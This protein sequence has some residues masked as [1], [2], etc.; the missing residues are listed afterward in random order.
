LKKNVFGM[1]H[2]HFE[3]RCPLCKYSVSISH[4]EYGEYCDRGHPRHLVSLTELGEVKATPYPVKNDPKP[5]AF[6]APVT[7]D[8][9]HTKE[10][11]TMTTME[12]KAAKTF[13][14][15]LTDAAGTS[16]VQVREGFFDGTALTSVE[17]MTALIRRPLPENYLEFLVEHPYLQHAET[18]FVA[19]AMQVAGQTMPNLPGAETLQHGGE[20]AA[21]ALSTTLTHEYGSQLV[22]I[23]LDF[24]GI[25]QDPG[26]QLQII[27]EK[28]RQE[29]AAKVRVASRKG[30]HTQE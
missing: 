22:G 30:D 6:T 26:R 17:V 1:N 13:T 2:V 11:E 4:E 24:V 15:A 7:D 16:M 10:Y 25:A 3:L 8:E 9:S 23:A 27:E 5:A 20:R 12:K 28:R 18:L 19:Y 14:D 29:N 21:R